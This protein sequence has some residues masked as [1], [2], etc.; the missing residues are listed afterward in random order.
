MAVVPRGTSYLVK[1]KE[2]NVEKYAT[3]QIYGTEDETSYHVVVRC[4]QAVRL[5]HEMRVNWTLPMSS[6]SSSTGLIGFCIC[7]AWWMQFLGTLH[8][9]CHGGC[10]TSI[11][12]MDKGSMQFLKSYV[13]SLNI[14]GQ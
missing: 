2:E 3:C 4:T 5:R 11:K 9:S 13:T 7:W 1:Q 6:N 12:C 10:G 14:A 8:S